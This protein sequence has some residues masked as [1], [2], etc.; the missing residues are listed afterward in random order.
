LS[1]SSTQVC[2]AQTATLSINAG[3]GDISWYRDDVVIPG[4]TG[5]SISV[6]ISGTYT[7]KRTTGCGSSPASNAIVITYEPQ[8]NCVPVP[9]VPSI[10]TTTPSICGTQTATLIAQSGNGTIQWYKNGVAVSGLIGT[11]VSVA[12]SGAYAA[13]SITQCGESLASNTVFVTYSESCGCTPQPV[14]PSVSASAPSICP[15]EYVTLTAIGGCNGTIEW[16]STAQPTIKLGSGATL[17]VEAGS[18]FAK[19]KTEC[20]TSSAS[21]TI[22]VTNKPSEECGGGGGCVVQLGLGIITC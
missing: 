16:Y 12:E 5:V 4:Q 9:T 3:T 6:N 21:N 8:C 18:Y 11:S 10:S 19:C 20:G 2:G 7:A 15:G 13:K 14:T 22:T 17:L 1:A